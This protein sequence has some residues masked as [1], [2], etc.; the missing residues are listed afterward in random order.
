MIYAFKKSVTINQ[1]QV[2]PK[3]T[4]IWIFPLLFSAKNPKIGFLIKSP[5]KYLFFNLVTKKPCRIW[6]WLRF[7][8]DFLR[9]FFRFLL[10]QCC[11]KNKNQCCITYWLHRGAQGATPWRCFKCPLKKSRRRC[12][13]IGV[14]AKI[15][16]KGPFL[17]IFVDFSRFFRF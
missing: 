6:Y 4:K 17:A 13:N 1:F 16:G 12:E 3:F 9:P 10:E 15:P 7:S 2:P 14:M 11:C 8:R 5:R